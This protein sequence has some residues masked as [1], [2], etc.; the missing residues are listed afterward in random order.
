MIPMH[1]PFPLP[2]GKLYSD[3]SVGRVE[4][5]CGREPTNVTLQHAPEMR[6]RL[7]AI[8]EPED[9]FHFAVQFVRQ[10]NRA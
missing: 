2:A 8:V 7:L 9:T 3:A 5:V 4:G 10:M 6:L 1:S